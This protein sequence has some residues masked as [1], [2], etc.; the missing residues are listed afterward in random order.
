MGSSSRSQC[1]QILNDHNFFQNSPSLRLKYFIILTSKREIYPTIGNDKKHGKF[2][3]V[4]L[5]MSGVN[6]T[7]TP[8]RSPNSPEED[9]EA[10]E[11]ESDAGAASKSTDDES[12]DKVPDDFDQLVGLP[13]QQSQLPD[14]FRPGA[15]E[16]NIIPESVH[17]V[18]YFSNHEQSMQRV[19][20]VRRH[21]KIRF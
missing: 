15:G 6:P 4:L 21:L 12:D 16:P 3:T 5:N 19:V 8:P 17:Y 9:K 1:C 2:R 14:L 10:E 18:G 7:A 11:P 20:Q 13:Q